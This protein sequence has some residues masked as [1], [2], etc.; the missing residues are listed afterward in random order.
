MNEQE[1]TLRWA[2]NVHGRLVYDGPRGLWRVASEPAERGAQMA[3]DLVAE[4]NA[5]V[6]ELEAALR[7]FAS[8]CQVL[9]CA[10]TPI[11]NTEAFLS[12]GWATITV[13]QL[14]AAHAALRGVPVEEDTP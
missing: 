12:P 5:R 13:G 10:G 3:I 2:H 7:P 9:D 14:R 6:R 8:I 1:A 11:A 4:L